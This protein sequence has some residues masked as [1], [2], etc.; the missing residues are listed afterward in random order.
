MPFFVTVPRLRAVTSFAGRQCALR[1]ADSSV[2]YVDCCLDT[3][4]VCK[5]S[6]H[7]S[8]WNAPVGRYDISSLVTFQMFPPALCSL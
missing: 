8:H 3:R 1:D 7:F 4:F 6:Q 5:M 2:M